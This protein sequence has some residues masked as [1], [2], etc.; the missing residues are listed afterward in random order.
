ML[1]KKAEAYPW[2]TINVAEIAVLRAIAHGRPVCFLIGSNSWVP[3]KRAEDISICGSC[4]D[5]VSKFHRC[6]QAASTLLCYSM[7]FWKCKSIDKRQLKSQNLGS[8][9]SSNLA[10]WRKW[11]YFWFNL[12]NISISPPH[13]SSCCRELT[14]KYSKCQ[15]RLDILETAFWEVID[16][17]EA[18]QLAETN[19]IIAVKVALPIQSCGCEVIRDLWLYALIG[20]AST[21]LRPRSQLAF[22]NNEQLPWVALVSS[23]LQWDHIKVLY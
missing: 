8:T 7:W 18:S 4:N 1:S 14:K 3:P 12:S 16:S 21:L 20:V 10:Q 5:L 2:I 17:E 11:S 6:L 19:L 22:P 23:G 15:A 13:R 9:Q